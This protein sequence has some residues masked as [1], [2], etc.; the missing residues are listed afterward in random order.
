MSMSQ[1]YASVDVA[2]RIVKFISLGLVVLT[3]LIMAGRESLQPLNETVGSLPTVVLFA[4]HIVAVL[5]LLSSIIFI[6]VFNLFTHRP[7][8]S[9]GQ[10]T[11]SSL[12]IK[13]FI[14][15]LVL[16]TGVTGLV[17]YEPFRWVIPFW[18]LNLGWNF[19]F[20]AK[21]FHLLLA[22]VVTLFLIIYLVTL[23]FN[24]RSAHT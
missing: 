8:L 9:L 1:R 2:Y 14:P 10:R 21:T 20:T 18:L 6:T 11:L 5:T 17:I 22:Y 23:V 3:G 4:A 15:V 13:W 16:I 12:L 19:I 7:A 24:R